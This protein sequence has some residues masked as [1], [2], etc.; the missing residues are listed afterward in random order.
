MARFQQV[1]AENGVLREASIHRLAEGVHIVN[2]FPDKRAF[3]EYILIHV[4]HLPRVWINARI[5]RKKPHEPRSP[6]A[7]QT[8]S[9]ARL[10]NA[11][12]LGHNPARDVEPRTVQWMRHCSDQRARGIAWELG[13]GVE[14]DDIFDGRQDGRVPHHFGKA[15]AGTAA[16]ERVE[17]GELSP[18][19][20]VTHPQPF[21]RVPAAR[22]MKQEKEG[23]VLG[24]ILPVE[25]FH[26]LPRPLQQHGISRE[27][28]RRRVAEVR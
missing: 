13:V 19:A 16:Q 4:G 1:M 10:H 6:G 22:A 5:T 17:L 3:Q 21:P 11:V 9:D 18:F 25:H 20:F 26:A 2:S 15:R 27:H 12:T 8:H 7:G 23:L 24:W 14:R 28:L